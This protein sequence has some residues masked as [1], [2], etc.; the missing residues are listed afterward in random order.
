MIGTDTSIVIG[1]I[2]LPKKQD[3]REANIGN[4]PHAGQMQCENINLIAF[5]TL[6]FPSELMEK[7]R[8]EP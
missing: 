5:N 1:V 2:P 6:W 3:I 7:H 8:N 4:Y